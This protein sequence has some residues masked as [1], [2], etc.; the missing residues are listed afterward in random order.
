[1]VTKMANSGDGEKVLVA[2]EAGKLEA[3]AAGDIS[4]QTNLALIDELDALNQ[5]NPKLISEIND[6]LKADRSS[7]TTKHLA[8]FT[9]TF[10]SLKDS[11]TGEASGHRVHLLVQDQSGSPTLD[12]LSNITIPDGRVVPKT[13]DLKRKIDFDKNPLDGA[14]YINTEAKTLEDLVRAL[15]VSSDA[16]AENALINELDHVNMNCPDEVSAINA[17]ISSDRKADQSLPD[18]Q[19]SENI[20]KYTT[21]EVAGMRTEIT[22]KNGGGT[23]FAASDTS[24]AKGMYFPESSMKWRY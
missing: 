14:S 21:G 20:I 6:Q 19:L 1:M 5:Q 18:I 8:N 24:D 22:V 13:W 23:F 11:I 4:S 2:A 12:A 16:T 9:L 3:F 10:D 17:K 7:S 15:P